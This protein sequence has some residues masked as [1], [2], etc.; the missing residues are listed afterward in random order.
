MY[1]SFFLS[2]NP[3]FVAYFKKYVNVLTKIKCAAKRFYYQ[4]KIEE[5]MH[6]PH[7]TWQVLRESIL[8]KKNFNLPT[9]I[10]D[11]LNVSL[12]A[13]KDI[14]EAFNEHLSDIGDK[15]AAKIRAKISFKHFLKG[16]YP[17]SV[18]LFL[19]LF[20]EIFNAIHSLNNK[21]SS[22]VDSITLHFLKVLAVW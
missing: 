10:S 6:N 11:E 12:N 9:L 18:A 1:K 8:T 4:K 21:K 7:I 5:E 20:V 15:L 2:G 17:N 22:R 19:P 3:A 14:G 16:R 13:P